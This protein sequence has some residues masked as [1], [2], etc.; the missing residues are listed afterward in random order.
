MIGKIV[1]IESNLKDKIDF[2]RFKAPKVFLKSFQVWLMIFAFIYQF[3]A[4]V[5][6]DLP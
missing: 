5:E 2:R 1:V 4:V 3:G 6:T